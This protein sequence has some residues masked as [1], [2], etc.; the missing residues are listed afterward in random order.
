MYTTRVYSLPG[1]GDC[2]IG[3]P[4]SGVVDT[5][6]TVTLANMQLMFTGDLQPFDAYMSGDLKVSGDLS[7]AMKLD[8]LVRTLSAGTAS[9]L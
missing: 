5:A 9:S 3:E 6:V 4:P 2:G 1:N 7:G 8:S